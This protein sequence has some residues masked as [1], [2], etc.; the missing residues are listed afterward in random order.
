MRFL[1]LAAVLLACTAA[2]AERATERYAPAQIFVA[3]DLLEH[4]RA[5][6]ALE[7]YARAARYA[8][9]A[10]VD[11]RIAWGMTDE[12]ALRAQAE[13]ILGAAAA[14]TTSSRAPA[15]ASYPPPSVQAQAG[16]PS[17]R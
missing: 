8:Q 14:L 1:V 17:L 3:R 12:P 16:A 7:D 2:H 15:A 6:A 10:Q 13:A 5:A 4:A 11:A 9:Q